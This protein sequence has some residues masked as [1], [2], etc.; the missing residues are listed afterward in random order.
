MKF[1]KQVSVIF[2]VFLAFISNGQSDS[3][4]FRGNHQLGMGFN[5]TSPAPGLSV[6]LPFSKSNQIQLSYS[7]REYDWNYFGLVGW[8]YKW[9]FYGVEYIHRF[10][11][12]KGLIGGKHIYVPFVYI[13]GGL[14]QTK[15]NNDYFYYFGG[16]WERVQDWVGYNL[17]MGVEVFP[18]IFNDNIG[19]V[20]KLGFGS[21]ASANSFGGS[22]NGGHLLFGGSMFYYLK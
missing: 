10:L 12:N 13:G 4:D 5:Y 11:N 1:L 2:L 21:Y 6:K 22:S 15:W 19:I 17:G 14:G 3:T 16:E 7:S 8:G 9:K 18:A 20:S